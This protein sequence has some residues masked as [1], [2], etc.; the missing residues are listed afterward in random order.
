MVAAALWSCRAPLVAILNAPE[1]NAE[2]ISEMLFGEAVNIEQGLPGWAKIRAKRDGYRGWVA[3]S[4]LQAWE[5]QPTHRV[6]PPLALVFS[7]PDIKS[8]LMQRLHRGSMLR[9]HEAG[10]DFLEL[11]DGGFI[12]AR[13]VQPLDAGAGEPLDVALSFLGAP[14]L[15]G[16]RTGDGIDCSA[17]VQ[18]SLLECGIDCPRDTGDQRDAFSTHHVVDGC[19]RGDLVYFPGHVGMMVDNVSLLHANAFW[20]TTMVEPLVTV[21]DRLRQIAAE[22]ILAVIRLA[23]SSRS[24]A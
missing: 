24:A 1:Q 7:R 17:L 16:G 18:T 12:H 9:L 8:S 19:R 15:W 22:P 11:A 10:G 4:A 5:G 13:H 14:Y 2:R 3:D 20:M 21:A 23:H 6:N